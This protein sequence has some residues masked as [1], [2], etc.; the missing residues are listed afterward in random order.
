M[1]SHLLFFY[2]AISKENEGQQKAVYLHKRQLDLSWQE[3]HRE[4]TQ[5]AYKNKGR[6]AITAAKVLRVSYNIEQVNRAL[7]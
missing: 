5:R 7:C 6:A 2:F 4:V 1:N 3:K